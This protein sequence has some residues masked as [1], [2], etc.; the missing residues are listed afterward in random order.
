MRGNRNYSQGH[1]TGQQ[2]R[3]GDLNKANHHI[4]YTRPPNEIFEYFVKTNYTGCPRN[5]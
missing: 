4:I 2:A 3:G 5:I 1:Q